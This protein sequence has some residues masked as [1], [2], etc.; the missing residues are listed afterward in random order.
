[1]KTDQLIKALAA[2]H[3]HEGL[4]LGQRL[5]VGVLIALA[6]SAVLFLWWLGMRRDMATAVMEPRFLLKFPVTLTLAAAAAGIALR[7]ARPGAT[8][9]P[10]APLLVIGPA[11]LAVGIATELMMMPSATWMPRLIGRNSMVCLASIPLL[12][13]PILL[14][15]LMV[16]RQGA[17]TRPVL[18]GAA[19][20]LVSGA[21]GAALYA[22][23]CLDDSPL[24]VATWYGIGISALTLV[25]AAVGARVL[26]W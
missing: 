24:F 22:L 6:V 9:G 14:A 25:G 17:P 16:L 13:A 23:H 5:A 3:A 19:A 12:A 7:L 10:W 1:M 26:R 2:D 20:G 8:L 4:G 11:L 21:L 15:V 18:A